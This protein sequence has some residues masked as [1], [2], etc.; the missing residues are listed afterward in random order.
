MDLDIEVIERNNTWEFII[1]LKVENKIEVKWIYK[2]KYNGD[3]KIGMYKSYWWKKAILNKLV[4]TKNR[5]MHRCLN[6]T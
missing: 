4:L 1:L 3:E 5:P 6:G 2:T